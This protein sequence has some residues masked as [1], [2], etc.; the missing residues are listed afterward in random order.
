MS[1]KPKQSEQQQAYDGSTPLKSEKVLT[2]VKRRILYDCL[3]KGMLIK[4]A[5]KQADLKYDYARKLCTK[6]HI[7]A[8]VAQKRGEIT[9]K[10]AEK[11]E[12]TEERV[13][14]EMASVGFAKV[15][16]KSVIRPQ[17]K[18]QG[19][20]QLGKHLGLFEKDNAQ[21]QQ[22]I[23]DILALVGIRVDVDAITSPT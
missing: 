9:Q 10:A 13:L 18:V 12:I 15:T 22:T 14:R 1:S 7:N 11:L 23:F 16:R 6:W 3:L 5:A 19:L 20:E 21:K 8:L 17:H 2:T 4:A